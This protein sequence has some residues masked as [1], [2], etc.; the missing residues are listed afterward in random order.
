M[1]YNYGYYSSGMRNGYSLSRGTTSTKYVQVLNILNH[2][3]IFGNTFLNKKD[4]HRM[5]GWREA[6]GNRSAMWAELSR[7]GYAQYSAKTKAWKITEEGI[8]YLR[9]NCLLMC[10]N[11][12]CEAIPNADCFKRVACS[13]K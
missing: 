6:H 10:Y 3:N 9:D 7:V 11:D 2:G 4:V 13:I 12:I 1:S 5:M 8:N